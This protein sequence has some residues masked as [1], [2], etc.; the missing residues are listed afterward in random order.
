MVANPSRI[1]VIS[2]RRIGD[3]LLTT[4]LIRSLRRA[5]P[6]SGIDVLV[7]ANTAGSSPA[8][9]TSIASSA[10]RSDDDE[11]AP[12]RTTLAARYRDFDSKR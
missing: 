11:G 3:L 4:P 12:L 6:D 10:C 9:L 8:I 2:L 7:F 5:W 1:L